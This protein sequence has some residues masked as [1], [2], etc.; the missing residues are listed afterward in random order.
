MTDEL[1][2]E[3]RPAAG[4]FVVEEWHG[5][6]RAVHAA[7]P[8]PV[9]GRPLAVWCVVAAPAL[10]LGSAQAETTIDLD[11]CARHG[12]DL[13]RRRSGGGAVLVVPGEMVWL[14]VVVPRSDPLWSD[15]VGRA[16][17]WLGEVWAG[18]LREL[19]PGAAVEVHR[20]ALE[21]SSWSSA[22][23]FDGLGAGEVLVGAAKAAGISQRRQRDTARLQ[24]S[25]HLRWRP[26]LMVELLAPPRPTVDD[27]RRVYEVAVDEVRLRGAVE[28]RLA[29]L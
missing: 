20:G 25:V 2:V 26:D 10:V 22:V 7:T 17:W 3:P 28:A 24:S 27:L 1:A 5:S 15:D 4:R 19:R 13:A 16:M 6:A 12:L 14:D 29:Q 8:T 11:A 9:E 18:A 23:C 21:R